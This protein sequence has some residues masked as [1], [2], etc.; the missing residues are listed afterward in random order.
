MGAIGWI[1]ACMLLLGAAR[2]Q[3]AHALPPEL[4]GAMLLSGLCALPLLW[5]RK[6]GL[7]GAVAPSGLVRAGLALLILVTAGVAQ[8]G[9]VIGLTGFS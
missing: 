7:L 4:V 1:W 6:T 9:A 5:N 3:F 8:P 2:A